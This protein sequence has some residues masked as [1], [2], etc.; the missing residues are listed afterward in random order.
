LILFVAALAG[1]AEAQQPR[2]IAGLWL[3][4]LDFP[5]LH[6]TETLALEFRPSVRQNENGRPQ[7]GFKAV[8]ERPELG[9]RNRSTY[10]LRLVDRR[11]RVIIDD[12][13]TCDA[14]PTS[15]DS[16]SGTCTMIGIPGTIVAQRQPS[17]N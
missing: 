5:Q 12:V 14:G 6:V 17:S 3:I 15:Y 1:G 8:R 4:T 13:E 2:T 16:F 11:I 10:F 9:P 7:R